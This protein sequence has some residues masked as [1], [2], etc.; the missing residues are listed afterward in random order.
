MKCMLCT[1]FLGASAGVLLLSA[2]TAPEPKMPTKN[3]AVLFAPPPT[4][5]QQ[6]T[7][8]E[9]ASR[10]RSQ[11]KALD[12]LVG[13]WT[14]TLVNVSAE[15][16]E[17]DPHAGQ[18]TIQW[19]LGNRYLSWEATLEV[20]SHVHETM[21]FLGYDLN[22]GEYQNL[23]IS[24]LATGMSVARGRGE[25]STGG[26]KLGLEVADPATG[27]IKRAQSTLRLI[28]GNHFV[29]EQLGID[30][31]GVERIVRRTHYRRL[32]SVRAARL[33]A[34]ALEGSTAL[35]PAIGG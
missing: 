26:I 16:V 29:L 10:P 28:D 18:S 13:V 15:G 12:P 31:T 3:A 33:A 24:D 32:G 17:S 34:P 11:H 6:A 14:T 23:M 35:S 4:L 27:A 1:V 7:E 8:A 22:T 21:G 9:K 5:E 2:C 20:G 19:V 25:P 30:T